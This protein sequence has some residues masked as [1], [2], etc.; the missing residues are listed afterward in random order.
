MTNFRGRVT[1]F[2]YT[3]DLSGGAP[4]SQQAGPP[5]VDSEGAQWA[6]LL[7]HSIDNN[8]TTDAPVLLLSGNNDGVALPNQASAPVQQF[9]G[10]A[11]L[12]YLWNGVHLDRRFSAS[13]TDLALKNGQGAALAALP[14]NW[15]IAHTPATNVQAT[16][17]KAALASTRHIATS[18]SFSLNVVLSTAIT[19]VQVNLRDGASGA[20]T[21]LWSMTAGG[22]TTGNQQG[23]FVPFS[24]SGLSLVG[25]VN[26]AMTLEFSAAAGAGT[27]ESV[28][29]TG[30]DAV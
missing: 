28:S 3:N 19:T 16:I 9:L 15:G 14:G 21:I 27:F 1:T 5:I 6:H 11:A 8:L 25:S 23:L 7:G 26:T 24:I 13:A 17:S 30:Y 4:S 18:I 10:V 29:L 2:G 20:G 22:F 12:G